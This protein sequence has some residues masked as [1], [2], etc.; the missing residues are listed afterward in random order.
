MFFIPF[1]QPK[2]IEQGSGHRF[3]NQFLAQ[4]GREVAKAKFR[5]SADAWQ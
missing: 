5:M 1:D 3:L 2:E 4:L